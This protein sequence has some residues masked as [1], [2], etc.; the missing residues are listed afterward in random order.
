MP[1]VLSSGSEVLCRAVTTISLHTQPP[2]VDGGQCG[3]CCTCG[4]EIDMTG[5]Q[6]QLTV[7]ECII[8]EAFEAIARLLEFRFSV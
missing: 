3:V 7:T 4:L 1:E 8:E 2:E 5:K 6:F